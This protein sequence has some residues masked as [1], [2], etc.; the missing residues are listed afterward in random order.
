MMAAAAAQ[1]LGGAVILNVVATGPAMPREVTLEDIEEDKEAR[2]S[3]ATAHSVAALSSELAD[4][5]VPGGQLPL[6]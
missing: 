4:M 2:P 3:Q 5:T 6:T 1:G